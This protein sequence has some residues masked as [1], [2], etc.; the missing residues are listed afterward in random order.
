MQS[1]KNT[2]QKGRGKKSPQSGSRQT[3]NKQKK[4]TNRNQSTATAGVAYASRMVSN[5]PKIKADARSCSITHRE[6]VTAINGSGPFAVNYAY[7]LNPGQKDTFAWLATQAQGWEKYRFKRL[8]FIYKTRC[9]TS[10]TGSVMMAY[11]YD[12]GDTPPQTE[13]AMSSYQGCSE[14]APWKE[15]RVEANRKS[16]NDQFDW[17]FVRTGTPP[18]GQDIKTLDVGNFFVGTVDGQDNFNWGK[19]W[20]EYEVEF[21]IPQLPPSGSSLTLSGGS[22]VGVD[23]ILPNALLGS[24]P[25]GVLSD[26]IIITPGNQ[27]ISFTKPGTYVIVCTVFGEASNT[28]LAN[29]FQVTATGNASVLQ[30]T[31]MDAIDFDASQFDSPLT[32]VVSILACAIQINDNA[33]ALNPGLVEF[34]MTYADPSDNHP[35]QS[36][37][38][39]GS[40]PNASLNSYSLPY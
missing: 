12:A 37:I 34:D 3:S 25:G 36:V 2:S 33:T 23:G 5:P 15:I 11:D 28:V 13:V 16:M 29:A 18:V 6:L 39:I 35:T 21:M 24:N 30:S 10:T 19:L 1:K 32:Y 9:P 26:D 14:D 22:I 7:A 4:N 38:L 31:N 20:V 17:H 8:A 40:A 27:K